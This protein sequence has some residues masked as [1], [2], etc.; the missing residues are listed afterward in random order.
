V[1]S[2]SSKVPAK[3][4]AVLFALQKLQIN[5]LAKTKGF[6]VSVQSIIQNEAT[7]INILD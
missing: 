3:G 5:G 1:V 4:E 6:T 7:S 2:S